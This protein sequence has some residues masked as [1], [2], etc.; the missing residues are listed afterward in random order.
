MSK[1][2]WVS[3]KI[4]VVN[5]Q[6][7]M[8]IN[9]LRSP[10]L[11]SENDVDSALHILFKYI[12]SGSCF[13]SMCNPPGGDWS[14]ISVVD[15]KNEYRWLTL[16]RVTASNGKRPDHVI[17][18]LTKNQLLCIESKDYLQN[19]EQGIGIKLNQYCLDLLSTM[20]SCKRDKN[21]N[22][23]GWDDEVSSYTDPRFD[24]ISASAFI[25]KKDNELD[26]GLKKSGCDIVFS[27]KFTT[28]NKTIIYIKKGSSKADEIIR[29][30]TS[31]VIPDTI[32]LELVIVP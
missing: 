18:I 25:Q 10:M 1:N 9:N 21:C 24:Y 29:L 14:G 8:T 20:P 13:E 17:Q 22:F 32:H 31:V 6:K 16:P 2:Q 23:E 26:I 27:L 5:P 28:G 3:T 12:L 7:Q 11:Y 4:Q 19:L 30:L 15:T